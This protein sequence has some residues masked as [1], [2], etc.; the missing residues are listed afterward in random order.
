M[1]LNFL[2][3]FLTIVNAKGMASAVD[4]SIP[5]LIDSYSIMMKTK[6]ASIARRRVAY[7]LDTFKSMEQ[8]KNRQSPQ[9]R[10]F[11][12]LRFQLSNNLEFH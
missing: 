10:F 4:T 8:K 11:K 3:Y 6:A 2:F 9:T 12:R 7:T 5:A 1:I